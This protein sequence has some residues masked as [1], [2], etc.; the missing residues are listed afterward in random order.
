MSYFN[1]NRI[2][3]WI[4][5]A[6]IIINFTAIGTI[7]YKMYNMEN[8]DKE[9]TE[10]PCSQSFLE[11]KLQLTPL[12]SEQFKKLKNTHY[13]NVYTIHQKMK[14]K[15]E[16]ISVNMVSPEPDTAS[17]HKAAEE[18]GVLYSQIRKLYIQHYFDLRKVCTPEQQKKLASI[19]TNIF[20]CD[21]NMPGATRNKCQNGHKRS[22][23]C[24]P[25][26]F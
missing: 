3:L 12:Q 13:D 20:S 19:Y 16:F 18:M 15:R 24:N 5:I 6:V 4:V 10:R 11:K 9:K 8:S 21:E 1:K 23:G 26:N 14:E 17:L 22:G 25:K 2:I 7:I